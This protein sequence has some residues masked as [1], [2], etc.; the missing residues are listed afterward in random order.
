MRTLGIDGG[1]ASIGW[2]LLDI[3]P[4]AG[5]LTIVATGVRTF[6]APETPKE[7]TP[8][9]AVRRLHRGQR[10]VIRRRRQ[11]MNQIRRL[12][13][14]TG[15]LHSA[16]SDALG[17]KAIR[18]HEPEL[19]PNADSDKIGQNGLNPW[20]LRAEAFDRILSAS[21]LAV[22]LGHIARHRGFKSN[23][24][25]D[26]GANA[27]DETSKMK[28]AIAAT[29][30]RLQG[31]RTVGQM[32]DADPA[33]ADRKRNRGDFTRSILRTDQE[34]E[35]RQIFAEQ[36]RRGN[37]LATEALEE[38]FSRI[39]FFQRPLQN[40][41]H[42]VQS[43]P[44]EPTEKR[45]ARRS[46]AFEMFRLLSR[47]ATISL[48]AGGQDRRLD[49]G[50]VARIAEDFGKTKGISYIAVRK[51]L[52]LDKRTRFLGVSE[53]DEKNDI[54]ARS[55]A[56]AEG[57]YTLRNVV[58]P[59]GWRMLTHNPVLRDRIAEVLSF[60]EDPAS[61]RAGL[62]EAGLDGL[63][64][65]TV[66]DGVETSAFAQFT[67][68]GHISAKAAR[69]LL[70]PL[71]LGKVYSEACE[72]VGFDHANR[73]PVSLDD[74]RNPVARNPVARKAVTE[75]CKQVRA[76]FQAYGV[77]DYTHVEL[78]RDIGKGPEERD[79]IKKGIE[80]QNKKR[81]KSRA[82]LAEHL[83]RPGTDEELLRYELWNEQNGWCL[84]TGDYIEPGWIAGGDN[85]V[86]VD[87][88]L[89][90]SRFGDDSF[91]NKTLCM[92]SANQAKKGRTP[93]EWFEAEGRDWPLFASRVEA[94]KEMKGR[95][96]GGFYLRKNAKEVEETF[97][98]RNLGDTRYAT[99]L[100]LDML[101]RRYYPD[102]MRKD[103][104]DRGRHVLARPGQLTAKLR[105]AWGLDDIKKDED[106]KRKDDDRHHALDAI[107][108]AATSE[109]MLQKL[110]TA[111]QEAERQGLHKGFD[112]KHVPLPAAGF[113]GAVRETIDKVFVSR[114]DR[115][116][117]RGEA[118]AATIK[119][120]ETIDGVETVFERKAIEKL[121]LPDLDLIPVPEPYGKIA[122][123]AKL[124]DAM[125]AELRRWIVAGKPKDS[126]PM[127]SKGD[128]IRKVRLATKDKVAVSVRGGVADRGEMAR[129]DVFAKADKRGTIRYYLVPIYPHQIADQ[130]AYPRP[131]N[132]AAVA[133]AAE[134]DW[135]VI[136]SSFDFLFSLYSHSLLEVAKSDGVLIRGYFKGMDR[137]TGAISL[138]EPTNP[139]QRNRGIGA[140]T[141]AHFKKLNVDRLGNVTEVRNE[142]RT[143]RGVA[144]T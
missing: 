49:A 132:L 105:R 70:E 117:A 123:P 30:E 67:R 48:S 121:T 128:V 94:C 31:Y 1:I 113:A 8:T 35:V 26:A 39:A 10:R 55:G 77:A 137:S 78:A 85:R 7:R 42:M 46:Y 81:D 43:C 3:D 91:M 9:N 89:P 4:D 51:T 107:V 125:V 142:V 23:A 13:N 5:T 118:H 129:V 59:S 54:V 22:A 126:P 64:L 32:F 122:D 36:R 73:A 60:R 53:K 79:R 18:Q 106:G 25:R 19:L 98:N 131:P 28:K 82:A 68:A 14:E 66:M 11:R 120:V 108:I 140:K 16:G 29:Q 124:R 38:D 58:G 143:W 119:R 134:A 97:R 88:I 87:H 114:A 80:D 41:E 50:E 47:L 12:L 133:Y 15:L 37:T 75:M 57:T 17:Q 136:D 112:F 96:K 6:D 71:R 83:G 61:I 84:Y 110:T 109:S 65:D 104:K 72:D 116:R 45:T 141:L 33:F 24:K 76:I 101:V 139:R 40:S 2:A 103:T 52:E 90:W 44:F 27:A 135:I 100:L 21:E 92:A 144:C 127:S 99:R 86:Q 115:H 102:D 130:Q 63:L 138:A 74:V 20:R 69:K 56:A 93:F 95:K 62:V 34:S 111:A